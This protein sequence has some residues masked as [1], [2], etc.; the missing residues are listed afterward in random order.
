MAMANSAWGVPIPEDNSGSEYDSYEFDSYSDEEDNEYGEV[1]MSSWGAQQPQTATFDVPI[2][3]WHKLMDPTVKVKA[4][5]LGSGGLHCKGKNY[6][7]VDEEEILAQRLKGTP[8]SGGKKKSRGKKKSGSA[9]VSG[10]P[11]PSIPKGPKKSKR[12]PPARPPSSSSV[13]SRIPL[14]DSVW[15]NSELA[16]TPFWE[17]AGAGASRYATK[18]T[19]NNNN[20]SRPPQPQQQSR[21]SSQPPPSV[22]QSQR[23]RPPPPQPPAPQPS[24]SKPFLGSS[25]SRYAN[26]S[27]AAPKAHVPQHSQLSPSIPSSETLLK[28]NIEI[29]PGITAV[30]DIYETDDYRKLVK[31]FGEKHHLIISEQAETAF[32]EK[33]KVMVMGVN[34]Q[35]NHYDF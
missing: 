24:L 26:P 11:T 22:Q 5:A 6:K 1:Q 32:A 23:Q 9:P 31:E 27:T 35:R 21:S 15:G 33:I 2:N 10:R 34:Q 19:S 20:Q 29:T 4:G 7:P 18:P 12:G 3:N 14:S 16:S 25:A 28:L 17:R 30:L 13:R 8:I